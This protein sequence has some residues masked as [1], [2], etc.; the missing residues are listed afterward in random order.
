MRH[1]I[2]ILPDLTWS[3][4]RPRWVLAEE[5]GFDH[6]WTYDHLVWGRMPDSRWSAC[7]PLLTAAAV[8]TDR[9][10]LGAFVVSPNFRHPVAFSREVETL[11]DISDGRFLL[12]LGAGGTPD[13]LV[14]GQDPLTPGQKVDRFREFVGLLDRTLESDHVDAD[15]EYYRARDMRLGRG[16]VRQRVPFILA[17]N[18][19]RSIRFAARTGE[20]WATTGSPAETIDEWFTTIGRCVE[21]LDEELARHSGRRID[22]YLHLDAAPRNSLESV[23]LFDEM[24]GRAAELGF[25]DVIAC[26]PRDDEP[27]RA[28][29][30]VLEA[31]A[32]RGLSS[33]A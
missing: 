25:T 27:Y 31:I 18:G 1:G 10:G 28:S 19:P 12:G 26:W 5:M 14:L 32:E 21:I 7:V 29:T 3:E 33:G 20:A 16:L 11:V 8:V 17:G 15:G 23:D 4:S 13:D 2:C 9:I 6:A 22:R 24:V 30:D